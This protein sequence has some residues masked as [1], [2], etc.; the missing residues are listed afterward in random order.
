M[1]I[2]TQLCYANVMSA[3]AI[4]LLLAGGTALAAGLRANSVTSAAVRNGS[5]RSADLKDG[6][7]VKGAD[8]ADGSLSGADLADGSVS[9]AKVTDGSLGGADI[10][11]GSLTSGD[12]VAG[13]VGSA[14]VA[15]GSLTGTAVAPHSI[16]GSKAPGRPSEIDESTLGPVAMAERVAGRGVSEFVVRGP[17]VVENDEVTATITAAC[18]PG[19]TAL[20]GGP[21]KIE[22][23]RSLREDRRLGDTW[24][25]GGPESNNFGVRV[26]CFG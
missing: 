23:G 20:S 17:T 26:V 9:G 5:L 4:G 12:F 24:V 7:A 6:A 14:A 8:V 21:A 13:A 10:A 11:G 25:V 3:I 18:P 1:R 2:R 15:D 19:M 22:A 16:V